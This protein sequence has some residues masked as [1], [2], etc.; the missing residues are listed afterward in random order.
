MPTA[1]KYM[2]HYFGADVVARGENG[3]HRNREICF[4]F[5]SSKKNNFE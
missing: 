4:V 1:E 5:Q 3:G 2:S